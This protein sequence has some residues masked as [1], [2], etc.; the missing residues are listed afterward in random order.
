MTPNT[1]RRIL[2]GAV[3]ALILIGCAQPV[4]PDKSNYVG[5]WKSKEMYLLILQD[6][7]VKYE[8]L[9]GGATTR[10]TGPLRTFQDDDFV[11]GFSFIKTTFIV[12]QPPHEEEGEWKMVVDGVELTKT[13]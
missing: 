9:K 1:I 5:E 3:L 13:R 12:T 4:P 6:G 2:P 10:I 7:S 8:R 11:V